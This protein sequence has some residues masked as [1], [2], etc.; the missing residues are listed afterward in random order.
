MTYLRHSGTSAFPRTFVGRWLRAAMLDQR[1][2]RDRLVRTLN[3]GSATGWNDDEPAVVE[4]A[5]ELVLR[6]YFGSR[7]PD[8]DKEASLSAAVT[9]GLSEILRPLGEQHADAVIKSALGAR[10]PAFDALKPGDRHV[11]R[12]AVVSI[13]SATMELDEATV[14]ELVREAERNAFERGFHPPLIPRRWS[15]AERS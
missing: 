15:A 1:E 8:P 9:V 3:G 12:A 6:R 5:A 2:E 11:L 10:S 7:A 13:A 14:D 4:A